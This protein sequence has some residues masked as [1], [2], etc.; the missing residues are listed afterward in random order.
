MFM[1]ESVTVFIKG[2]LTVGAAVLVIMTAKHRMFLHT[3]L[4]NKGIASEKLMFL[5]ANDNLTH[6]MVEDWPKEPQFMQAMEALIGSACKSGRVRVFD[7]M[8]A[9]LCSE[10]KA[11]A[12]LRLE[13]LWNVLVNRH[14]FPLLCAYP[15]SAMYGEL[16]DQILPGV[17]HLHQSVRME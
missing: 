11:G 14:N 7:E 3:L 8:V 12:A 2:G 17:C 5:D 6:F 4:A 16:G 13:E 15:L 10:G 1:I 9:I